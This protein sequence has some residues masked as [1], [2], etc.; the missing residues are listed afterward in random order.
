[1]S[2]TT[3]QEH[4]SRQ[5][6]QE[7]RENPEFNN[8][9]RS[10][11][12]R[13]SPLMAR[14]LDALENGTD[15]GRYG[16]FTFA[17]VA[18]HFMEEE[19]I[20]TLLAKQPQMDEEKARALTIQV[21]EHDYNPPRRERILEQ[22]TQQ[23]FQL[24]PDPSDPDMGNLYRELRFPDGLYENINHYYEDKAEAETHSGR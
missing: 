16:Q 13:D 2:K 14:L 12:L 9:G 3:V 22:Q 20:V 4:T 1:M 19:E 6:A 5:A 21:R 23:E 15:I 10:E 8:T 11:N 7:G 17:T 24:I 18:R